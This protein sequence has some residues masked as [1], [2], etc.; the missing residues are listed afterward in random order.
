MVREKIVSAPEAL[1]SIKKGSRVFIGSGCGEPQYLAESLVEQADR[2]YDVEILQVLSV[3][4]Q[5]Y[6]TEKLQKHFRVKNFFA[7]GRGAR[8]A[9]W[10]G[11][12]EYIPMFMSRVPKLFNERLVELD[13]A[14]IQVSPP[15]DHGYLSLGVAVDAAPEAVRAADLVIAQ[16]NP[17]MPVTLG[18]SFIHIS[19]VDWLVEHEEPLLEVEQPVLTERDL[20]VG[21][22]VA[23]LVDDGATIH[24]GLG[25]LPTAAIKAMRD[26]KDLGVHTDMLTDAYMG[27]IQSGVITNRRKEINTNRIV[28]SYA[29]GTKKLYK[30]LHM[31]PFV[32]FL[33]VSRTNDPM[34]IGNHHNMISIHEAMEVDLTGLICSSSKGN[35]VYSGIGGVVDFMR[36]VFR[37]KR[38]KFIVAVH[39]TNRDESESNIVPAISPRSGLM[40][41]RAAA[42]YIVTEFG[43]VNLEAKS[44]HDRVVALIEI[45]HPKFREELY[46]QA[47]EE[48]LLSRGDPITLFKPVV[49]PQD[50]ERTFDVNNEIMNVRPAKAQDLRAIQEFFYGMNDRDIHFRFLRSMKAFPRQEIAAIANIDYH[51]RMTILVLKGEFG[52][53]HVV[54]IGRYRAI[55][56]RMVEVDVAVA[57]DYRRFGIGRR[58][59]KYV[60]EIAEHKGFK[61]VVA[62]IAH[63]NPKTLNLIKTMG[64]KARAALN[65]GTFEVRMLFSEPVDEPDIEIVYQ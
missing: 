6:A 3:R 18:E 40:A 28:A 44:I 65:M 22:N 55:E 7:A 56:D 59:M 35:R 33:P 32:E 12:A 53:E 13:C 64:Y 60:F 17:N 26:K 34:L 23:R 30:Y 51:N 49:Y 58:L 16:I 24:A 43:S 52:F 39:A 61:G 54:A 9:V 21:G 46:N 50:L 42:H 48:G 57:E 11:R 8:E 45:A 31:N 1:A 38:G 19:D 2:L 41:S 47:R 37:S 29:L 15:D 14:M 10:E 27:L 62:Y 20:L 36:G 63:D 4:A 25:R 5:G